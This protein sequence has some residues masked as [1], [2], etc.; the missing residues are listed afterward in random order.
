ML[1]SK[2]LKN[3]KFQH[4]DPWS[5]ILAS[6]TWAIRSLVFTNDTVKFNVFP[7]KNKSILDD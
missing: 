5:D 7:Q 4:V 6:M 3:Y 1:R 2:D